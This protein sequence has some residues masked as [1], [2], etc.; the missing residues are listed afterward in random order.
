M[1]VLYT[2]EPSKCCTPEYFDYKI[3]FLFRFSKHCTLASLHP[4]KDSF[5]FCVLDMLASLASDPWPSQVLALHVYPNAR[6]VV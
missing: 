2:L 5:T 3:S 6:S 1:L 4:V